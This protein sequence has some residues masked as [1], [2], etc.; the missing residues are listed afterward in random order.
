MREWI[1]IPAD[2]DPEATQATWTKLAREAFS[3]V[4]QQLD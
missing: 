4:R 1:A 2:T 3:F